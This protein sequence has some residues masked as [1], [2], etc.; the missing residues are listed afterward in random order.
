MSLRPDDGVLQII[1]RDGKIMVVSSRLGGGEREYASV[2]PDSDFAFQVDMLMM[3]ME[4]VLRLQGTGTQPL[5]F[6]M[7]D[8]PTPPSPAI[9][10]E[11]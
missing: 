6:D 9:T 11:A 1:S 5:D 8:K 4:Y 3:G 2:D 7:P 10:R